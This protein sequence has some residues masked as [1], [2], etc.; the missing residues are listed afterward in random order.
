MTK[1]IRRIRA[2]VLD[3]VSESRGLKKLVFP[4]GS[5]S[6]LNHRNRMG[7][8]SMGDLS[9]E[10]NYIMVS[11]YPKSGN[12]W[13]KSLIASMFDLPVVRS[14]TGAGRGYVNSTH[15]LMD[16][17]LIFDKNLL[18]GVVIIRDLRDVVSSLFAFTKTKHFIE[19]HGPHFK[20]NDAKKF[21]YE[22]F[23]ANF[24]EKQH[25]PSELMR[26]YV[27]RGWPVIRYEDLYDNPEGELVR[28]VE[29]WGLEMSTSQIEN[30][31]KKNS[32]EN[33]RKGSGIVADNIEGSHFR[34]GGYGG[35]KFELPEIVV[36]DIETRFEDYLK[37]WGYL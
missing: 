26:G 19:S 4:F 5:P 20:F 25:H 7:S 2:A 14:G 36:S 6:V 37:R 16:R 17:N 21:Y 23:L 24:I 31:I 35:Y 15:E 11:G 32:L 29:V 34:R 3:A 13:L 1:K 18:R 10:A 28:L 12:V 27:A 22:Y 30:A 8:V 9:N 33:M